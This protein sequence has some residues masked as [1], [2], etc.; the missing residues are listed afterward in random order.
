MFQDRIE[1]RKPVSIQG[2]YR[3]GS[4]M[5]KDVIVAD[6]STRGCKFYDRFSGL[7]QEARL[8]IRIGSI[9]PLDAVVR[10]RTGQLIGVQ[11]DNALHESVLDH[12]V[13]TISDWSLPQ[14]EMQTPD[15]T[16]NDELAEEPETISIRIRQPT[17]VDFRMAITDL[18]LTFPLANEDD[19]EAVFHHVLNGIFVQPS[20]N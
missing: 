8:T 2:R 14:M 12:M 10:W 3:T 6:M 13:T 5:A 19:L 11:F 9:G 1:P 18:G 4:G 17:K 16:M 7:R 15:V 20:D